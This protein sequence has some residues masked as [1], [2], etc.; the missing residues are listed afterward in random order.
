IGIVFFIFN[1]VSFIFHPFIVIVSTVA[2]PAIIA[3]I[4]Y[5]LMNP[6]VN[7]LEKLRIKRLWGIIIIILV[8]LGAI[9]GLAFLVVPS[10]EKQINDLV[11]DT[12]TYAQQFGDKI[13]SLVSNSVLEPYYN[14]VYQWIAS[15]L[16][17]LPGKV[18]HS[19]GGFYEGVKQFA[20]T[21]TNVI[22]A[23]VTFPFVLFFLLKDNVAFKKYFIH[24]LPP[25]F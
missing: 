6:L 21:I 8:F 3:F 4:V 5:Y 18:S 12:P 16:S 14:K 20:S 15:N 25:K 10:I 1:K 9:A 24:L 19:L 23:L 11:M 13:Q 22:I 2:P 7:V 17:S